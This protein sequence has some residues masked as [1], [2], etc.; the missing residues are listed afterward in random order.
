MA[1]QVWVK[2]LLIFLA[3]AG[4]VVPLFR[5][6]RVGTVLGFLV[7][8]AILGPYGLGRLAADFP[9]LG[10]VTFATAERVAPFAELGIFFLL[11]MIGLELSAER[12]WQMRRL[13]FGLGALQVGLTSAAI[14]GLAYLYGNAASGALVVGLGLSFASTAIVVPVLLESGRWTAATGR[15][16]FAVLLFQDL[17]VVP[18]VL[19]VGLLGRSMGAAGGELSLA[20]D[21][22]LPVAAVAGIILAGRFALRPLLRLAAATGSRELVVAIAFFVAI[23][24]GLATAAVGMSVAL[25]AFLAGLLL[26]GSEFR[27][28]LEV[29]IDPF[30]GLF[31]GLFFMTIGMGLDFSLLAD[32]W[33]SLALSVAGLFAVKSL[34]AFGA[35]LIFGIDLGVAAE[36]ALVL[37]GCGEFALVVLSLAGA[38]QLILRETL[39]FMTMAA[40]VT[41]VMTPVLAALG[42]R[43]GGRLEQRSHAGSIGPDEGAA[44]LADHVVIGGYGRVG[45]LVA[46]TLEANGIAF[47]GLDIDVERVK[48]GRR[49]G[50][51]V[52][53]GDVG[54]QEMLAQIGADSAGVFVITTDEPKAIEHAVRAI[55]S[56][57]PK[58]AIYAR[59]RDEEDMEKLMRLGATDVVPEAAEA[60]LKLAEFVLGGVGLP[61]DTIATTLARARAESQASGSARTRS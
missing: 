15:T 21:L 24:S 6:L 18:I 51:P 16:A 14:A 1:E 49:A 44:V 28:Q 46:R 19:L 27:H 17:A 41:M 3:T 39:P 37:A 4:V 30:K 57:W 42:R 22:G 36:V 43:L 35:C 50:K 13:V 25:G 33:A 60:G 47:V 45:Q 58:A 23:G 38:N 55:R 61:E 40:I 10:Y 34:V 11:F 26:S 9:I 2:D 29:D 31:L 54:R 52:Y 20:H 59:A 56:S 12:L 8:G 48:E 7:A 5:R 53:F 32:L